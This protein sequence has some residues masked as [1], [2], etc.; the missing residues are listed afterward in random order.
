MLAPLIAAALGLLSLRAS[1]AGPSKLNLLPFPTKASVGST[2]VCLS[3]DFAIE[4]DAASLGGKEAPHDLLMAIERAGVTLM[5]RRHEY[6]S[7][8]GGLEF[9][10]DGQ[11]CAHYLDTLVLS[12][13]PEADYGSILS[14]AT[15][16]VEKRR[17]AEGYR[18]SVATQGRAHAVAGTALGLFRGLTTFENLVYHVDGVA[19]GLG[20]AQK[21]PGQVPLGSGVEP[22]GVKYVPF[23]P[24]EIEDKPAF[25]WRAVLLDTSRH[26]FSKHSIFRILDTMAMVKLNVFHWHITDSNSWPL[27]LFEFPLLAQKGAYRGRVYSEDDVR[28]IVQYAGERG[29]DVVMEIDTPGHTSIIGEAYPDYIACHDK[30]PWTGRAHQPPAGQLRFADSQVTEFTSKL[31]RAAMGVTR[32]QYFGTGGDEINMKCMEEDEP[33]AKALAEKG[34]T[35]EDALRDFTRRTH[36]TL[37]E[38]RR[39]A[40]AIAYNNTGLSNNTVVEIWVDSKDARRVVDKGYR[41]VHAA[42]DYFYLDCG[43]G[44]WISADGGQ[45]NS[46]CDPFKTWMKIISFDPYKNIEESQRKLVLGGQASLWAEQT[47]EANLESVMWPRAAAL[48]ELF[49]SGPGANGYPRS[50]LE[51][52]PRMHD[53]RYRILDRGVRAAPL[54]PEWC[55]LR[56][57]VCILDG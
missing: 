48:A 15:A 55:A 33:T 4:L 18:L 46:W 51:A 30:R 45:G 36:D 6:L 32:S 41:I 54:Q 25:P 52:L 57:G 3:K 56:P 19:V 29:I 11:G 37:A 42:A 28:D 27:D 16:P 1:A 9:F 40:V 12:F 38:S 5:N 49:W 8:S 53:I 44:G 20:S 13:A 35:I 10:E 7:V 21:A 31:F 43:Q 2:V 23:A 50:V 47:D 17:D 22:E 26:Y 14:H 24:Y 34:W 39:T